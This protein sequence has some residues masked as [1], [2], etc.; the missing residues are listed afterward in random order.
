MA[1][2]DLHVH[3][4]Y[5]EHPSE[6]FLQRIGA[7]ESYTEPETVYRTA[8]ERGMDFVTLT[9]HNRIEGALLLKEMYPDRVFTGVEVTAYFPEDGCKAHIL[10]YGLTENDFNRIQ[11]LR[12]NIYDLRDF[13][14]ECNLPCSVAHAL[15]AVNDRLTIEHLEKLILLFD[16]FEGING[17]RNRMNNDIW[18]ATLESLTPDRIN[19]LYRKYRIEPFSEVPWLKGFTGGSDDH[20]GLFIAK[21]F[22]VAEATTP[23]EYLDALRAKKSVAGGRHND[24]HSLAFALYKV[25]YDFSKSK[26]NTFSKSLVSQLSALLFER[27]TLKLSDKLKVEKL[28]YESKSSGDRMTQLLYELVDG[29]RSADTPLIEERLDKAYDKIAA[30]ADEFLRM[31]VQSVER[32]LQNGDIISLI[33]N[34]SSSI[35]GIFL[36]MPFFSTFRHLFESR[37]IAEELERR[38]ICSAGREK[39]ILWFTD[40]FTDMNG[41]SMTLRELGFAMDERGKSN[42]TIV[43]SLTEDELKKSL[44]EC[45]LNL[46]HVHCFTLPAYEKYTLKV[47][48]VLGALKTIY[49]T[50]PDEIYISTP[51]PVGLFGLLAAKLLNVRCTG[52]YHTD[53]LLQSKDIMQDESVADMLETY[54]RW[55][56]SCMNEIQV[57][58]AGYIEILEKRGYNASRLKVFS[59]G[60]NTGNFAPQ[61]SGK[62]FLRSTLGITDGFTLLYT[63]RV[64]REKNLDFL[65][66]VY[67]AAAAQYPQLNL[68]IAGDGPHCAELQARAKGRNRIIF[69]GELKREILPELYSGSDL[70]VFPSLTDTFG[71]AV[72]EA[73]S[74]GLPA[75][76]SDAGGPREL[77]IDGKTGFIA[78]GGD[79]NEWTAKILSFIQNRVQHEDRY[80]A[81]QA[82][83]RRAVLCKHDW[84]MIIQDITRREAAAQGVPDIQT[85]RSA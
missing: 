84:D 16:T 43:T 61:D 48:A 19:D 18:T 15:Y 11:T 10:V 28:K 23:E 58:S 70:F 33:R 69:T 79:M 30:I 41:V 31:L 81:M 68:I 6:W 59:R 77:I 85:A 14:K 54:I 46:P 22:T 7:S 73:Q 71:M 38:F 20:G 67:D 80:R 47:P 40:T 60:I 44:P 65:I 55:F 42:I 27:D 83:A 74:C 9:D 82:A 25:A 21:T 26:S 8:I 12:T 5:S 1:K 13:L 2:V 3:S 35:P 52:V 32:D 50:D 76:V 29:F 34:I 24:F 78:R 45:V 4:R 36:S 37:K 56:Y 49:G 51:G 64:S 53:F 57:P 17:A 39:S 63:G 75:I 72:L 66:D 62:D